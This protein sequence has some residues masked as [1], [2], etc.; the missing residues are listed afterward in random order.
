VAVLEA[1]P[2]AVDAA[3]LD[4]LFC[5][6]ALALSQR[7]RLE[8]GSVHLVLLRECLEVGHGVSSR[9]QDEDDRG[10][11]RTVCEGRSQV[12]RRALDEFGAQVVSDIVFDEEYQLFAEQGEVDQ[13][14]LEA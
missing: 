5:L 11:G 9:R 14:F 7:E 13:Q 3:H 12:E 2:V 8:P 4:V 1:D 10:V 6:Y